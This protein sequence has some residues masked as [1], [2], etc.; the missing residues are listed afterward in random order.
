GIVLITTMMLIALLALFTLSQL[1][2]FRLNIQALNLVKAKHQAFSMLE[3]AA[4]KIVQNITLS[5]QEECIFSEQDPKDLND[6]LS[7]KKGCVLTYEKQVFYYFIEDLG[8]FP[9]LQ[10]Q[11]ENQRFSMQ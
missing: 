6:L 5:K 3:T 7:N 1:Q 11:V 8:F 2:L 9:C 10:A 4:D